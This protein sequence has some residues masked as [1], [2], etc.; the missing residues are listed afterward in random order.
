MQ[1]SGQWETSSAMV[2]QWGRFE[3]AISAPEQSDP[4]SDEV[5]SA[6]FKKGSQSI[7]VKGFYDGDGVYRLR[8]MPEEVGIW[9]YVTASRVPELHG[10]SGTFECTAP[11]A[12]NH[13]YVTV[14]N[15]RLFCYADGTIYHPFGTTCYA[16]IH[17]PEEVRRRTID[18]LGRSPF[19]KLRMTVFPKN[20]SFNATDPVEFPY[21]GS[22]EEGFDF[23]RFNPSF[24]RRLE[25][26]IDELLAMGIEADLILFH[27]YDEG[28]WGFDRMPAE[29]DQRY[30][31]YIIARL[32][33]FR[34]V[35]WSLANE[36]DFMTEK[37]VEQWDALFQTVQAEDPFG[38]LR[39]IHNGT[40]MYEPGSVVFYD[41]S[42]E[43]VT[44]CSIQHW[45]V[46]LVREWQQAYGKPIVI[47]ECLYEGNVP[48]R[49]GNITAEE[50]THR[51]WEA[52][53]RGGYA[54]H[55]ETY[56]HPEGEIWWAKGGELR[57][58]SPKRIAF[59]RLFAEQ[60]PEESKPLF[61]M[62][63]METIGVEGE[64]YLGYF[65]IHRPA[66]FTAELD[67]GGSYEAEIID[68]WEM[69]ITPVEGVL[70]GTSMIEL[71]AKPGI[72]LRI[73]KL[74]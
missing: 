15:A 46:T 48:F 3:L 36:Y 13:G 40:R 33:S 65:G 72:A 1:H 12:D 50:M 56:L 74:H 64:Y 6:I 70:S 53:V 38:H 7:Q 62:R 29:A 52:A 68:T 26:H 47:D 21:E 39:S 41:H 69:T 43:W 18:S 24:F 25:G 66:Y 35:W 63:Q 9:S 37:T 60:L 16:W 57:G 8:F 61:T 73:R 14:K 5:W 59:L 23:A 28:R 11:A 71:P 45:D 22:P 44:H 30:L 4:F 27:P 49:W 34:N 54:G 55:G 20:Y 19:N 10:V 51:F 42:R 17:Q 2:E 31:R 32:A 67:E 58:G